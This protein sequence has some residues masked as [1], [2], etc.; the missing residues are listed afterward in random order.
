[1]KRF[2]SL[3]L[4]ATGLLALLVPLG[5]SAAG[6]P[7]LSFDPAAWDYGTIAP[8]A[9]AS[10]AFV[11][12]NSGGSATA[13]L[14]VR[15][16]GTGAAAFTKTS[17]GCS[18]TSLG[19]NKSCSVTV[20]YSPSAAGA[21]DTATLMA[22]SKK[23]NA[24]ASAS[25]IGRGTPAN[26]APVAI[27]DFF[28]FVNEDDTLPV[29]VPGVLGN[30]VDPD[31]DP[32]TAELVSNPVFAASFTLNADGSFVYVPLLNYN[33]PD[34]F[35]YRAN[36]GTLDSNIATVSL[37]VVPVNDAPVATN[38]SYTVN[39]GGTLNGTSVLANDTDAE[40]TTLTAVLV[41]GPANASSFT[42]NPD[43]T[44][45][46]VHNGSETTTDSFTY[47]ANDGTL[48]SNIATV[49]ITVNPV[50]DAPVANDDGPY[51]VNEGGT[52]N[53]TSV[54]A[55]DT[56]AENTTLTAV[57]VSGPANASSFTLNADG[58]F[59]YVHN[60]TETTTDSFTYQANDGTANSNIATV[61]IT[62]N[63]VNDA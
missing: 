38:D 21:T 17:D 28:Y 31:G 5:A 29:A 53:G 24:S 20:E 35:T 1:M 47:K 45:T 32:L 59:T 25:L 6:P 7:V 44:F 37:T 51:N 3:V 50:N 58:T 34:S 4:P 43:G 18:A 10:K 49:T 13:A 14:T 33:G 42:F 2:L 55:N 54:L 27:D 23:P 61:T 40:N 8:G 26:T 63:P 19:K 30:D 11:L 48:D 60:G 62:V 15:I 16:T 39:E 52:L 36:D 56:D 9:K 22:M 57:L 46:Y 12:T 41:S